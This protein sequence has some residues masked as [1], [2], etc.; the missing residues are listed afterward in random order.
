VSPPVADDILM[1]FPSLP[2][3]IAHEQNVRL[4][5]VIGYLS[6]GLLL[7]SSSALDC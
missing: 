4:E 2:R 5:E 1:V 7:K 3:S 6:S